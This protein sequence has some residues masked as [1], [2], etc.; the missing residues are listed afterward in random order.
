VLPGHTFSDFLLT[1]EATPPDAAGHYSYG[2]AFRENPD[3]A[4][5]YV[6]EIG[7]DQMYSLQTYDGEWGFAI[8]WTDSDAIVVN[9]TNEITIQAVGDAL[10]FFINGTQVASITDST[11]SEG[12]VGFVV[13]Q[14]LSGEGEV[15]VRFD[16]LT[17]T[18][19]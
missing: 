14:W 6:F 7:N 15:T 3:T 10:T 11:F 9:G 8:N 17:I 5:S 18:S 2:V 1:V 13:E 19:P 4:H 12:S 16:N